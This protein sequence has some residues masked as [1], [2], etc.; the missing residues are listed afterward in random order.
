[1]DNNVDIKQFR[2][3][4]WADLKHL[5][6]MAK[7]GELKPVEPEIDDEMKKFFEQEYMVLMITPSPNRVISMEEQKAFLADI[8]ENAEL[9]RVLCD[10]LGAENV[11]FAKDSVPIEMLVKAHASEAARA[12]SE[13]TDAVI[14]VFEFGPGKLLFELYKDGSRRSVLRFENSSLVERSGLEEAGEIAYIGMEQISYR[15]YYTREDFLFCR[16][17]FVAW[18]LGDLCG[19]IL[20]QRYDHH[21]VPIASKWVDVPIHTYV[22]DPPREFDEALIEKNLK[23]LKTLPEVGI[24]PVQTF[25]D[26][27]FLVPLPEESCMDEDICLFEEP[28]KAEIELPTRVDSDSPW[29]Y[30]LLKPHFLIAPDGTLQPLPDGEAPGARDAWTTPVKVDKGA[31]EA[32]NDRLL[33]LYGL[34][35]FQMTMPDGKGHT[36]VQFWD[37][38]KVAEL[39]GDLNPI[40]ILKTQGTIVCWY[41]NASGELCFITDNEAMECGKRRPNLTRVYRLN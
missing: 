11:E 34:M 38:G 29:G 13:V 19:Y 22:Y 28:S 27:A 40:R 33:D 4:L 31:L 5:T 10:H 37:R 39:D 35:V 32:V 21:Y 6:E 12:M 20:R 18:F 3:E 9:C 17:N 30:D 15:E 14:G 8:L 24:K 25:R 23:A 2:K 1:M 16:R 41:Y 26:A 36:F 7:R